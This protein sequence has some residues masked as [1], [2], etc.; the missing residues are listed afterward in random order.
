MAIDDE[1]KEPE[2]DPTDAITLADPSKPDKPDD[3]EETSGPDQDTGDDSP[4]APIAKDMGWVPRDKFQGPP[5]QWKDA[6]AFIR[7]GRDI[8]RETAQELKGLRGQVE[9]MVKTNSS[10]VQQQVEE[11]VNKLGA[12]YSQA[13]DDGDPRLA[14][15]L[16]RQIDQTLAQADAPQAP[17]GPSAEAQ[18]FAARNASWF[19]KDAYA[20]A[21]AVEICNTLAAQGYTDHNQQLQIAEQRLKQEMPQLF[22]KAAPGVNSPGSRTAQGGARQRGFADMP[23][24]AQKIA[25]DMADRGV[26]TKTDDYVK[27]YWANAG[28]K[29]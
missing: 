10:I 16:S 18:S 12:Q 24:A 22:G 25:K 2:G 13:V 9:T 11:R 26:I 8:Q 5:E 27:N 6:E 7:A 19:Q 4:V 29:L 17:R 3:E 20:T 15:Q 1:E 21:R 28:K 23:A 14:Y